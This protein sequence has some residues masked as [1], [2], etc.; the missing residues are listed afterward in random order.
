MTEIPRFRDCDTSVPDDQDSQGYLE[1]C[2]SP[3]NVAF[4]PHLLKLSS[5]LICYVFSESCMQKDFSP[6]VP[7]IDFYSNLHPP[8]VLLTQ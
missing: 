2:S 8:Q 6:H 5:L 1:H 4:G 3:R 7:H